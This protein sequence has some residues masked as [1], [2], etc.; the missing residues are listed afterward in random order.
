MRIRILFLSVLLYSSSLFSQIENEILSFVDSTELIIENGRQ[1]LVNNL[2]YS[3]IEKAQEVYDYLKLKTQEKNS[4]AFYYSE[5][6]GLV[7]LFQD[8]DAFLKMASEYEN[9][10][11]WICLS[12]PPSIYYNIFYAIRHNKSIIEN[13]LEMAN[14]S[15]N[16]KELIQLYL[17]IIESE[18]ATDE[19]NE[20]LQNYKQ[21][22]PESEYK[23]FLNNYYWSPKRYYNMEFTAGVAYVI[24]NKTIR[25]KFNSNIGATFSLD[26]NIDKI[27]LSVYF[28]GVD[29][30]LK[31]AFSDSTDTHT[32]DF[33]ENE[34][35]SYT[36]GGGLIGYTLFRN[37]NFKITPYVPI[38]FTKVESNVF[39]GDEKKYE[40]KEFSSFTSGIGLNNDIM[41]WR[42]NLK[43]N[44]STTKSFLSLKLQAG[45]NIILSTPYRDVF[46]FN[47][48]IVW[49]IGD[50]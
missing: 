23:L 34:A 6:I 7:I 40:Y 27:F 45:Y 42:F 31:Y 20:I 30:K 15:P 35:L 21:K 11:E 13:G 19:Y 37:R 1:L 41:I 43:D 46:Y 38:A 24:P 26:F 28:V 3:N 47:A 39:T 17:Y 36:N 2:N 50:F 10:K 5:E 25:E 49:G 16:E 12:N 18:E 14:L 48:C 22:Y 32:F 29:L 44:Y 4:N 8:W 33:N 9:S